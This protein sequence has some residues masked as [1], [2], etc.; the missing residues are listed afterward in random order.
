MDGGKTYNLAP[1]ME[2]NHGIVLAK[3]EKL[4]RVSESYQTEGAMELQLVNDLMAQG[5]TRLTCKTDEELKENLKVQLEHLNA[6]TFTNEEWKRL[7][8]EFIIPENQGIIEKTR[9]FQERESWDFQFDDGHR[10]NIKLIDA[11]NINNN[12]VQ[13]GNQIQATEGTA[14]NRYDVTIFVNG[15]PLVH[16]ELKKRGIPIKEAFNQIHRYSNESFNVTSSLFQYVQIFVISNGTK[17]RYFANTLTPSKNNYEFTCE[18]AD[19]KNKPITDLEDF[20]R[21]FFDKRT[22]LEILTKYCVFDATNTL[23]IMRPYQIA[24]AERIL[25][26]IQAGYENKK[27]GI[28]EAG[29]FIWHTTGSGKTLTSYKAARLATQLPYIDKVFFVVDRKDLDYQ[30]MVEYQKFQKDCVNGSKDTKEL[31]RNISENTSRIVVTTIQKLN[32]FI[33]KHNKHDIYQKHCVF[34]YDE[35]HRSQ[36]GKVQKAI[37]S[38]F[39]CYYQ[40]GF[41]GTPIFDEN[42]L[43]GETTA[44]IFGAQLHSYVITDAIR[45]EKVLKFK[46]DYNNIS[47][48]FKSAETETDDAELAKLESKLL[49]HPERIQAVTNHILKV[50]PMKTHRN[51][52]FTVRNKQM[53]GFNAMFAVQS[54]E[55]AKMYYE[56]FKM[57]QQNV[58]AEKRLK[59]GVIYSFAANE[60]QSAYGEIKDESFEATSLTTSAKQFL[61]S[62]MDDYNAMF[63][64]NFKIEEFQNYYKD[65][66]KRVK[67]K[68]IDLL[69]VVGMFLTGFDAPTL[70]T[71]FVDKNLRY[72]GLIQAFSRTNRILN[73]E[74][75]FGNI[76]CFRDLDKATKE[77]IQVFGDK[78]SVT[79]ILER[80]FDDYMT[81]FIDDDTNESYRGYESICEE[82][83]ANFPDPTEIETNADKKEFAQLFGE[84]LKAE[85]IL[86]NFDEF[87][88]LEPLIP[89]RLVQDMKS[90]YVDIKEDFSE[91]RKY[92]E[93]EAQVIDLSDIEFHIDLLRTDEINLDYIL[94]LIAEKTKST[95]NLNAI[96][97]EVRRAIRSSIGTRAKEDLI[98]KFM[99]STDIST[100]SDHESIIDAF[101]TF[102]KSEKELSI[103]NTIEEL[104]IQPQVVEEARRYIMTSIE[105]GHA[106]YDGTELSNILP[107]RSR[108]RGGQRQEQKQSAWQKIQQLVQVFLGI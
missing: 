75:K 79:T 98:M 106:E 82:L 18:W 59:V 70:N 58:P 78:N 37:R 50:F 14:R 21:T 56:A 108:R 46:V 12:V 5:Y 30:T 83:L 6:V 104:G 64:S 29:G 51:V 49:L 27:Q 63:N 20:T 17:T 48:N 43:T 57:L 65:L 99:H 92:S 53:R 25:W 44:G 84:F 60:N 76:V 2:L 62:A 26:K 23:L 71:L 10:Q 87:C 102:A 66:A 69:I 16:I 100:L 55:A 19:A 39:K 105:K 22:I 33:Q 88:E 47:A 94:Q 7:L 73:S 96:E 31:A 11:T 85:N 34:I 24:A 42:S 72:H 13:V 107:S 77:A 90:I 41:T 80:S 3:Y 15:L 103:A 81:G 28:I 97:Q 35:C 8:R 36:F 86:R 67:D 91:G 40:F 52:H 61:I 74:K 1:I 93:A 54:V 38:K 9:K 89:P 68:D 32:Q 4:S 101:Y 95:D 45:D